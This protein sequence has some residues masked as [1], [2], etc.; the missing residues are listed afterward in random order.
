MADGIR[1]HDNRNHNPGTYA[2][3]SSTYGHFVEDSTVGSRA[4]ARSRRPS[5]TEEPLRVFGRSCSVQE[6][7]IEGSSQGAIYTPVV[8]QPGFVTNNIV[9]YDLRSD[10]VPEPAT[11]ALLGLGLAGLGFSRRRKS[12]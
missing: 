12:N 2:E 4:S 7:G 10:V 5:S 8:G 3:N 1:T 9:N 6:T 11:I